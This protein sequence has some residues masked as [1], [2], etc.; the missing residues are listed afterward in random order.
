MRA[1]SW[2]FVSVGLVDGSRRAAWGGA[3][4]SAH[5]DRPGGL[6]PSIV[7]NVLANYVPALR[8]ERDDVWRSRI[9]LHDFGMVWQHA[10]H[11]ERIVLVAVEPAPFDQRWD[12]FLGAYVEYLC[13]HGDMAAPRWVFKR[14]RHLSEFWFPG[15]RFAFERA[16]TILTTPATFESHGIWFP[17]RELVVV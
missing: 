4:V 5:W 17:A 14:G 9:V 6:D 15:P 3:A 2:E 13:Y 10:G 16:A 1:L 11:L 12:A 7:A 8:A